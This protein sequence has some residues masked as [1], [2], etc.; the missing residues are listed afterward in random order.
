MLQFVCVIISLVSGRN[1]IITQFVNEIKTTW[2]ATNYERW[3]DKSDEFFFKYF[4]VRIDPNEQ[5]ELK[6]YEKLEE[7]PSSFSSTEKWPGCNSIKLV[8]DQG[9]CG[10]CWAVSAASTMSDRLCISSGQKDKRLISAEDLLSCCGYNCGFE[11]GCEGGEPMGAWKYF[12]VYGIVTGGLYND[13]SYCKSYSFPP[14]SHG[15]N[16]GKYSKCDDDIFILMKTPYC[17]KKCN[18]QSLRTYELDIIKSKETPKK[19]TKN[20]EQI[21][22]EIYLNGPVQAVFTV[23]DDFLNYK[24]GVYQHILGQERGKHAVKI[25]GWGTENGIPYWEVVNSWNDEWGI[26]GKFKILRGSNHL[27]I[28]EYVIA[29]II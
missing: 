5:I 20:E 4:N 2:T 12:N 8:Y 19:I 21:K 14:C 11:E 3:D 27:G 23:Y 26:N 24:S 18:A 22:N 13:F 15:N 25:I 29:S 1:P 6:Y 10:S 7:L 17:I 16:S 9:N 28:E